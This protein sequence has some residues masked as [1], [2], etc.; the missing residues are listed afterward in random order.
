MY[1]VTFLYWCQVIWQVFSLTVMWGSLCRSP[2]AELSSLHVNGTYR[3]SSG[4]DISERV[5]VGVV[6]A[7]RARSGRGGAG[8]K[9]SQ[10]SLPCRVTG[11]SVP[12]AHRSCTGCAHFI[13]NPAG[14]VSQ[15]LAVGNDRGAYSPFPCLVSRAGPCPP[16][17]VETSDQDPRCVNGIIIALLAGRRLKINTFGQDNI[18]K[19]VSELVAPLL[20]EIIELWPNS[21]CQWME[22]NS[23]IVCRLFVVELKVCSK[24]PVGPGRHVESWRRF[25]K[26]FTRYLF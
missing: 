9:R 10:V 14:W 17:A 21:S 11:M 22:L 8:Y 6:C 12:Y 15:P 3:G 5:S 7:I 25:Q 16:L 18:Q 19:Q 1:L 2:C 26:A 20:N 23:A 24:P 13:F 4:G